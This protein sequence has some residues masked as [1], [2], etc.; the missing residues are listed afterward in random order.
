[1]ANRVGTVDTRA[2]LG[3]LDTSAYDN[4]LAKLQSEYGAIKADP[5][6]L[7]RLKQAVKDAQLNLKEGD[8]D[9]LRKAQAERALENYQKDIAKQQ[10]AKQAEI[11]A[12]QANKDKYL[13]EYANKKA[14]DPTT[15]QYQQARQSAM[16]NESA[17]AQANR[18]ANITAGINR[19]QAGLLG[20]AKAAQNTVNTANNIYQSNAAN[21]AS[22]Q[23]DYLEKMGQSKA[24]DVTADA[25]SNSANLVGL[26]AGLQGFGAGAGVGAA[27]AGAG[28]TNTSDENCKESPNE[29]DF[30]MNKLIEEC[31]KMKELYVRLQ[32]LK[33]GK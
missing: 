23:A 29:D 22:T 13:N 31:R 18:Q 28:T 24:M 11:N 21:A 17:Q 26:S 30:D 6:E 14:L 2:S 9:Y 4:Q 27:L 3:A 10:A 7:E 1:M 19:S 33:G 8:K 32:N 12:W 20:S 25:K 5:K 15:A 16:L